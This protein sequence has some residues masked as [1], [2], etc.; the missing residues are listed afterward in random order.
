[1]MDIKNKIH[2]E[3]AD[4]IKMYGSVIFSQGSPEV[5]HETSQAVF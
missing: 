2:A 4:S 5:P 1:M 3:T